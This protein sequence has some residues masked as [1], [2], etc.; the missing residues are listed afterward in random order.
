MSQKNYFN[1]VNDENT[2]IKRILGEGIS[3]RIF[4]WGPSNVVN[5][6]N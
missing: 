5:C 4:L 2:G 6:N 1:N 3:T